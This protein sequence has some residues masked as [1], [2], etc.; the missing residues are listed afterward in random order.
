MIYAKRV[1]YYI[2]ISSR[3]IHNP[4]L[5]DNEGNTIA[6]YIARYKSLCDLTDEFKHDSDIYNN[7]G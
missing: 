3:W 7:E 4:I 2:N 5:R 6:M 1:G